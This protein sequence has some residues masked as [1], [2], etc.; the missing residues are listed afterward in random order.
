MKKKY[1][2][3]PY[4]GRY[5]FNSKA[6]KEDFKRIIDFKE[7]YGIKQV[8]FQ[9]GITDL[10]RNSHIPLK[11]LIDTKEVKARIW[12]GGS[13]IL[14]KNEQEATHLLEVVDGKVVLRVKKSKKN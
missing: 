13:I 11:Y 2:Y 8:T 6:I 5:Q 14:G 9:R 7:K 3:P 10:Q 12:L 4:V 1:K